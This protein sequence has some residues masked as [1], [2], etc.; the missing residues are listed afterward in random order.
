MNDNNGKSQKEVLP[1]YRSV[2]FVIFP[3]GSTRATKLDVNSLE[4]NSS[5]SPVLPLPLWMEQSVV[6]SKVMVSI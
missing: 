1:Y 2:H 4:C 6:S 5:L 3:V